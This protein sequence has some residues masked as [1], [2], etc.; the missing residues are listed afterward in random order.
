[1]LQKRNSRKIYSYSLNLDLI[2]KKFAQ[3]VETS[4][5]S[6]H[7]LTER[8]KW[9]SYGPMKQVLE[10]S[11]YLIDGVLFRTRKRDDTR[12]T[13]NSGVSIQAS[14]MQVASA[15]DKNPVVS[16]ELFYGTIDEI[17]ELDYRFFRIVVFKC[18]WANN[19]DAVKVD[20]MGL[21][22]VNLKRIG[23]KND[24]FILGTQAKLVFY[25]EDPDDDA[26][27]AVIDGPNKREMRNRDDLGDI[28]I[29]LQCFSRGLPGIEINEESDDNEPPCVRQDCDGIWVMNNETL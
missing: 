17:W 14:V 19:N 22:L 23:Y 3:V 26:W 1:M 24:S 11:S 2:L 8:V 13:Q 29:Q 16:E 7:P 18:S 28:S 20:D 21:T 5:D 15:K 10:Y 12:T 27:S 25:V 4:S 6:N 9:L